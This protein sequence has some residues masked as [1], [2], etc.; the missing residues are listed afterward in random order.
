MLELHYFQVYL[1]IIYYL[2]FQCV[3]LS[4]K[5]TEQEYNLGFCSFSSPETQLSNI[6]HLCPIIKDGSADNQ[7]KE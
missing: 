5:I 2:V 7:P 3:A 4:T 1:Q 6:T